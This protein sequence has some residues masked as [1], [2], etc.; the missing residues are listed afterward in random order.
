[1]DLKYGLGEIDADRGSLHVDGPIV[2]R[3]PTITLWH[4][5]CRER[6]PSTSSTLHAD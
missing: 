6:A 4:I 5:R 3:S 1:V 2:N